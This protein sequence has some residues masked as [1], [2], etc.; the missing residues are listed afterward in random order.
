MNSLRSI[1]DLTDANLIDASD[2]EE[3]EAVAARYA[4]AITP[5]VAALIDRDDPAD[6]I[7]R[8]FVPDMRELET[9]PE[10]RADPIGDHAFSPVEGVVHRHPDRVLLKALHVC[11]VYCRFC[12][13][14]EMVGPDGDGTLTQ[15]ELDAALAY[16][17]AHPEIWEV[18]LTGGDPFMLSP[19]RIE[20]LTIAL[21]AIPHVKIVRWHTR[22]PLVDPG[23]VSDDLVAALRTGG[24]VPWVAIHANHPREFTD[25]GRA[26]VA[27][28]A[29]AG[30]PLVSQTVLL[31]GVNDNA[32]TLEALMRTFVE[33]RIKPYYLHHAD[34]A[35]GTAHFRTTIAE[36]QAL[37][38]RLRQRL[39]GIAMPTYVLDIPGGA[40]KVPVGPAYMGEAAGQDGEVFVSDASGRPHA[41]PPAAA[42]ATVTETSDEPSSA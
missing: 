36:G 19:R 15:A 11:P 9:Q 7:A 39:S 37:M 13:R 35:P 29:D 42:A 3:L 1:T 41:Y 10:E 25:E 6:P 8:Q 20:A 34:L 16:I 28:L 40:G 38:R 21:G 5:E 30:I 23:H 12:F 4:V 2:A 24:V 32:A 22:V 17:R 14:R 26:A 33:N 31:R 18:I 27:R